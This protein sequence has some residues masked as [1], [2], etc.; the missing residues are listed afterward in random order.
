MQNTE[1]QQHAKVVLEEA[2]DLAADRGTPEPLKGT[3]AEIIARG[4][5]DQCQAGRLNTEQLVNFIT[6]G[7]TIYG[8]SIPRQMPNLETNA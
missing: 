6:W 7:I 4:F 3:E 8:T 1:V 5:V 2:F